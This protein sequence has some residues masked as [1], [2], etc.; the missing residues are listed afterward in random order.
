MKYFSKP[1]V[2]MILSFFCTPNFGQMAVNQK[3]EREIDFQSELFE[4]TNTIA[5]SQGSLYITGNQTLTSGQIVLTLKKISAEG[6]IVWDQ[7]WTCPTCIAAAGIDLALSGGNIYLAGIVQS[8]SGSSGIDIIVQKYSA[9]SGA[10]IWTSIF[11]AATPREFPVD[12]IVA[13]N[14]VA[15]IG[16]GAVSPTNFDLFTAS[17]KESNGSPN[18]I[19][20]YD[21]L[22]FD[23]TAVEV[24]SINNIIEVLGA[25]SINSTDW[26]AVVLR[27][28]N[29][30]N[31][32]STIRSG[33]TGLDRNEPISYFLENNE[34]YVGGSALNPAT[35]NQDAYLKKY[36]MGGSTITLDW[37]K[38]FDINSRVETLT[39]IEKNSIG[40]VFVMGAS[41]DGNDEWTWIQSLQSIDG[42]IKWER[43]R[44]IPPIENIINGR[45]FSVNEQGG[46]LLISNSKAEGNESII[47]IQYDTTGN[48][49]WEQPIVSNNA[50]IK[51]S[52]LIVKNDKDIFVSSIFSNSENQQTQH[53][54]AFEYYDKP[55]TTVYKTNGDPYYIK[56]DIIIRFST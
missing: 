42:T 46:P 24:R 35:S 1:L 5:D 8:S 17:L 37:V 4:F 10:V 3:W 39:G 16:T 18:W 31:N 36:S 20:V 45:S 15:V 48:R 32:L 43:V 44:A 30:G 19:K 50:K 40:D 56:E 28:D 25:S 38:A 9:S 12:I 21:Y 27:Y 47:L 29:L 7:Q 2:I 26:E 51:G 53:L 41:V 11:D 52:N 23:E 54:A 55:R 22:G 6:T 13:N 14:N 49:V 33:V 34:L